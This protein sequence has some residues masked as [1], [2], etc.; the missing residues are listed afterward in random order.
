[1]RE[2]M[3]E[4]ILIEIIYKDPRSF[5]DKYLNL[6]KAQNRLKEDYRKLFK[7]VRGNL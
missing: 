1:M 3:L 6:L 7:E 4:D 5:L 2:K